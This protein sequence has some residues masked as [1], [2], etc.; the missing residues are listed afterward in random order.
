MNESILKEERILVVDE[1]PEMK[2]GKDRLFEKLEEFFETRLGP[3]GSRSDQKFQMDFS[4]KISG[5]F[6][7]VVIK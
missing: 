1:D 5:R 2:G 7:R 4:Q 3:N 6:D